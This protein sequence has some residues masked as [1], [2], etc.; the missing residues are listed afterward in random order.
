MHSD[1]LWGRLKEQEREIERAKEE[2]RELPVFESILSKRNLDEVGGK[3]VQ[4]QIPKQAFES[5]EKAADPNYAYPSIPPQMRDNFNK[6]IQNMSAADAK[7]EEAVFL[8]ELE[9]Q[10]QHITEAGGYLRAEGEA[11][12]K[13]YETGEASIGDRIK[14]W[15][16]WDKWDSQFPLPADAQARQAQ[17]AGGDAKR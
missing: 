9:Q 15:T 14:Q 16:G 7:V 11:R 17:Q 3:V 6:R 4:P 12:R 2:G 8:A 13:R 1:K 5:S 10:R